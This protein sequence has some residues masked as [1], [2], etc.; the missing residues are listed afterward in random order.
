MRA[1][2]GQGSENNLWSPNRY[3]LVKK[4]FWWAQCKFE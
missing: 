3:E 2:F 1:T 4:K